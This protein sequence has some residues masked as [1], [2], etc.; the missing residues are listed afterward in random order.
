MESN[1]TRE[2]KDE[3]IFRNFLENFPLSIF[4][5]RP[6]KTIYDC[7]SVAELYLLKSKKK[8]RGQ[9]FFNI[10]FSKSSN[11]DIETLDEMVFNIINFDLNKI[12]EFEYIDY[13]DEK[14]FEK[15]FFSPVKFG[16]NKFILVIIQDITATKLADNIIK[17]E[18]KR[19]KDLDKVKKQM[20]AE[21]TEE[22]KSP[23]HIMS[24]AA[25]LLLNLYKD[26]LDTKATELL[27]M[28]QRGGE[29]S[30]DLVG[31]MIDI[32]RIESQEFKLE[33][34]TESLIEII[35]DSVD[36]V[37]AQQTQYFFI[38]FDVLED[39]YAEVDKKRIRQVIKDLLLT[40][41]ENTPKK[42]KI[43]ISLQ[44]N[45][46]YAKISI[47]NI[48]EETFTGEETEQILDSQESLF[49]FHYSKVIVEMHGG[50]VITQ[51]M[52]KDRGSAFNIT[53]PIKNWS[54]L[55]IHLYIIYKSGLLIYDHSF[56]GKENQDSS[57]ISGG[58][59][60]TLIMLK[61]IMRGETH[62]RTI[63]HGDRKLMFETNKTEDII[64]VL[65]VKENLIV[66]KRR[67]DALI[68]RFDD[69]YKELI[70]D[71]ENTSLIMNYWENLD[72]LVNDYFEE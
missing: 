26:K 60:G 49:G 5:L 17:D 14:F 72:E 44:K 25:E 52:G 10:F 15:G 23:L 9:N 21:T 67:L 63:D 58:I 51:S 35:R 47:K 42:S 56:I 27:E 68:E 50:Q 8:L 16:K 36:E 46:K 71:I 41:M 19:L 40:V 53:L 7:N 3:Q 20:T 59:I 28:I 33:K 12:I 31:K 2:I 66:F 18:Y 64:F 55:L 69:D 54:D 65:L 37:M 32:S 13:K 11:I 30:M 1:K 61:E 6:D 70:D 45:G 48:F 29:R 39:L 22:L 57:L 38:N 4:I 24:N 34:Q 43:R 62:I